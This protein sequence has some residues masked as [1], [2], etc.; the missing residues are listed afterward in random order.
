ML[1]EPEWVNVTTPEML[2]ITETS[3][4]NTTTSTFTIFSDSSSNDTTTEVI[5]GFCVSIPVFCV[6]ISF[7]RRKR[8]KKKKLNVDFPL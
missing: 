1:E 5:S 8:G 6:F 3:E 2:T 7:T 4:I